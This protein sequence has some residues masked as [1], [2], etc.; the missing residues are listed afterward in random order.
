MAAMCPFVIRMSVIGT[1][2]Y[3][4]IVA[5]YEVPSMQGVLKVYFRY[6]WII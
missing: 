4:I 1:W 3:L 6:C 2:P 5:T